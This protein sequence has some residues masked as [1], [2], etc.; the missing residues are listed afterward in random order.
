LHPVVINKRQSCINNKKKL[1]GQANIIKKK[2]KLKKPDCQINLWFWQMLG[3][4]RSEG[5]LPE[6]SNVST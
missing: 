3:A 1:G 2:K 6:R 5:L 4:Q